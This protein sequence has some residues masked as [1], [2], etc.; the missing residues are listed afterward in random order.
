MSCFFGYLLV[1]S[2]PAAGHEIVDK[3]M[4][5]LDA[6]LLKAEKVRAPPQIKPKCP[7]HPSKPSSLSTKSSQEAENVYKQP[8]AKAQRSSRRKHSSSKICSKVAAS[9]GQRKK[10]AIYTKRSAGH[11]P[12]TA[13][14]IGVL[15]TTKTLPSSI[16]EAKDTHKTLCHSSTPVSSE[17]EREGGADSKDTLSFDIMQNG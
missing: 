14:G 7:P 16:K 2:N 17:S 15:N 10:S 6:V 1:D 11:L 8:A 12:S 13:K 5:L 9:T 4:Q 3:E